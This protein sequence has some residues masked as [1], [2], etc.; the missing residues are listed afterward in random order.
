MDYLILT[1]KDNYY[2]VQWQNGVYLGE[3][4]PG[5]DGFYIFW[6]EDRSGGWDENLLRA[7]A[8]KLRELNLPWKEE[9]DLYFEMQ[10]DINRNS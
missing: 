2:L 8:D 10:K 7:L 5:D 6:P 4:G 1:P 9:I 3:F